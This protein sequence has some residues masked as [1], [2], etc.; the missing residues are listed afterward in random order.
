[1][2]ADHSVTEVVGQVVIAVYFI[3]MGVKNVM[4]WDVNVSRIAA[5]GL[6]GVP[7]LL[8]GFTIQFIG[9]GLVLADW[10]TTVGVLLLLLFTVLASALFHRYWEMTD[11]QRTYHFLL[12]GCNCCISG[13]LLLLIPTS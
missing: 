8:F 10:Q 2:Y 9:A 12:L 5:Q 13:G 4:L 3:F 6:P 1:M 7:S 11:P